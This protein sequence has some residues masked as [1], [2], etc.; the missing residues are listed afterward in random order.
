MNEIFTSYITKDIS[1]LLRVRSPDR[2]VKMIKHLADQSGGIIN[3]S[4][5]ANDV[6]VTVDTVKNYLWYAEQTFIINL[7]RPFFANLKRN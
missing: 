5:L 4:Q 6:G 3:Y 7:V 1:F 2:F